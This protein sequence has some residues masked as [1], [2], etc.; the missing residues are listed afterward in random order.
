MKKISENLEKAKKEKDEKEIKALQNSMKDLKTQV[1]ILYKIAVLQLILIIFYVQDTSK[2]NIYT[3]D[4][5]KILKYFLSCLNFSL[6]ILYFQ[7]EKLLDEKN[8]LLKE[9]KV[10]L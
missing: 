4:Q 10:I 8:Y 9:E 3:L 2:D 6:I 5:I 7:E 1:K